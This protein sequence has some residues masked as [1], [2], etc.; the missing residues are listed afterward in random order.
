M[1]ELRDI[2]TII[3]D[4]KGHASS[5][6]RSLLL[7]LGV[8]RIAALHSTDD[9]LKL[10]R[11]ETFDV[12]FCDEYSAPLNPVAFVKAVRRDLTTKDVTIPVVLISA[13]ASRKQIE[14]ARD[15]GLNDVIAK[16]VSVDTIERKLRQLVLEPQAFVTAKTFLGPDRRRSG[17]ERRGEPRPGEMER[18]G[19][20]SD[21]NVFRRPPRIKSDQSAK[22]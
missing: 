22:N 15:S 11:E 3:I 13:G 20:S 2:R 5:L 9:A 21:G 14:L 10:M 19:T 12:V 8:Q 16:P 17:E 18:R 4:E 6:V 1:S 7:R